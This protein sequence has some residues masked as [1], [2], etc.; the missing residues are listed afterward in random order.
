MYVCNY[1]KNQQKKANRE[2]VLKK[3]EELIL[4]I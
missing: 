1:N 4:E 3:W 2:R